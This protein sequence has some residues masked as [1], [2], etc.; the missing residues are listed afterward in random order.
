MLTFETYVLCIMYVQIGHACLL[1][2]N[3]WV[4]FD[5][6]QFYSFQ[7]VCFNRSNSKPADRGQEKRELLLLL[8]KTKQKQKQ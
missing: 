5:L 1:N 6:C 8:E 4:R 2:H 7:L 3:I